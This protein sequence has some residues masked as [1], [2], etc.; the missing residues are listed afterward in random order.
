MKLKRKEIIK[1]G[2]GTVTLVPEEPGLKIFFARDF[3]CLPF[4]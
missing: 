1:D 3:D 2:S 4:N